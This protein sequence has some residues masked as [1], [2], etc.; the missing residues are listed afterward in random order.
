MGCGSAQYLAIVGK[1][2]AEFVGGQDLD[3][4]QI[5]KGKSKLKELGINGKL[6]VGNAINLDFPDNFFDCAFF[7]RFF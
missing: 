4:E 7:C 1:M 6:V 3:E 5:K 2:G